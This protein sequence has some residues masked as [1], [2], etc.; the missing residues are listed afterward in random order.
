MGK[1]TFHKGG[2]IFHEGDPADCMY[3][4]ERGKVGVYA[5]YGS[6]QQKLLKEYGQGQYFGEMGLLEHAERSATAAATEANTCVASVTEEN[7]SEFIR[8]RPAEILLIMQQ[9][10]GNLRKTSRNFAEVCREIQALSRQ[11]DTK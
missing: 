3:M 4:V 6:A 8:K 9:L 11:E 2:V 7:F 5:N 1:N 10:S